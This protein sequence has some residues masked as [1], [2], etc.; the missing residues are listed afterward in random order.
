MPSAV[1]ECRE[2]SG[3]FT[4]SGSGHPVLLVRLSLVIITML[5][6]FVQLLQF[7]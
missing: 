1:E 6:G 4:L 5:N 3:N 2:P 7:M